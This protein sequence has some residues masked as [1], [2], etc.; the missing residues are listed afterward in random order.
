MCDH[1]HSQP[2]PS[3][4]LRHGAALEHGE[5]H[6]RDHES[7]SRRDFLL[8]TGAATA[9]M[10]VMIAGQP[11][12]AVAY[13]QS[14]MRLAEAPTDRILV[15]IQLSGGNDAYNMCVPLSN[16][17]YHN[18]RPNLR[19]TEADTFSLGSYASE[20][21]GLHN[22]MSALQPLWAEGK[23]GIIHNVGYPNSSLSHFRGTDI[24]RTGSSANRVL[25]TGWI[26]RDLD[27]EYPDFNVNPPENPLAV[28]LSASSTKLFQGPNGQMGMALR[29]PDEFYRI[30][31]TGDLY[32]VEDV[33][34]N[35]YGDELSFMRGVANAAFRYATAIKDASDAATNDVAYPNGS[36][37]S[38]LAIIARLIKGGLGAKVYTANIGSFDT[39]ASQTGR[40]ASLLGQFADAV[41]AFYDDLAAPANGT[42]EKVLIKTQSE[43]GRRPK[44]NGSFGTDHGR[45]AAMLV[46]SGALNGG[47]YGPP[48]DLGNLDSS[49]NAPFGTDYRSVYATVLQTW[50]GLSEADS[51]GILGGD[52]NPLGFVSPEA[53][54]AAAA[55]RAAPVMPKTQSDVPVELMLNGN[56]PNPFNGSTVITYDLPRDTR[57]TI[58]VFDTA[59][60]LVDTVVSA[61]QPA[62]R[63]QVHFNAD[64]LP[65]GRYFYRLE[66]SLG[67][68]TKTMTLL[69]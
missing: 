7:W 32:D 29:N 66:T 30:A 45:G 40:H 50:F 15:I 57:V 53:A 42:E 60:R 26:G 69:R 47:F 4:E 1:H 16:D 63:H 27:L 39:H 68:H 2:A 3:D 31:A 20:D 14:L 21:W 61:H 34:P 55:R 22:A 35:Q 56:Y 38:S 46:F 9:G 37:A 43:F 33:P 19:L 44:Q 23:M 8:R 17:F 25:Q 49:G 10:T 51:D 6:T 62:G 52:F 67:Y 11:V 28:E 58:R 59:G 13:S 18:Y 54:A 65:S 5:A 41:K 12:R 64:R 48:A 36:L 24:W